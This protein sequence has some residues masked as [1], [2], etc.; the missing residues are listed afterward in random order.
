MSFPR[1][2]LELLQDTSLA[3][4][5]ETMSTRESI[6]PSWTSLEVLDAGRLGSGLH[7]Q[8]ES[9]CGD[10][11]A[12]LM[13]LRDPF[14]ELFLHLWPLRHINFFCFRAC[15][16]F[17]FSALHRKTFDSKSSNLLPGQD[18][19]SFSNIFLECVWS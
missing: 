8:L 9:G 3:M 18:V 11:A 17:S 4:D 5:G 2:A 1:C 16:E 10:G 14:Q 7:L 15:F 13:S 19:H 6:R 12:F